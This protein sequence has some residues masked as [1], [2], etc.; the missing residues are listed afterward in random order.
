MKKLTLILSE[1]FRNKTCPLLQ[2]K[3]LALFRR[4]TAEDT[5][6]KLRPERI[7]QPSLPFD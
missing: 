2:K 6:K 7:W 5:A 3:L 1:N 4:P